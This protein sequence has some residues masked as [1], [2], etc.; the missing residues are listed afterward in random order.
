MKLQV[1]VGGLGIFCET[2]HPWKGGAPPHKVIFH[3]NNKNSSSSPPPPFWGHKR[4]SS[5]FLTNLEIR[6]IRFAAVKYDAVI[7]HP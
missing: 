4:L 2:R 6:V 1:G 7:C 3:K 5:K